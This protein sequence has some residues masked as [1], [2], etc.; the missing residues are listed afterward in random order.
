MAEHLVGQFAQR[1]QVVPLD[2]GLVIL[3][4]AID[5]KRHLGLP[6][7]DDAP[8]PTRLALPFP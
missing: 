1:F 6:E 7:Q 8:E 2:V 3:G 5:E 4:K